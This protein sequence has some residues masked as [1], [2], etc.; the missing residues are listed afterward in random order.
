MTV[1]N[2]IIMHV[3][4]SKD[5]TE[6]QNLQNFINNKLMDNIHSPWALLYHHFNFTN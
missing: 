4:A 1:Q 5:Y 3:F 6:V 2:E